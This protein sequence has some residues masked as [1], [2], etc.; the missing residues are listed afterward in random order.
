VTIA[1]NAKAFDLHFVLNRLVRLKSLPKLLIMKG[2]K[3]IC[4]KVENVTWLG[5]L[6]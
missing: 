6:N 5:S 4:L 2:Q 3:I 1:H